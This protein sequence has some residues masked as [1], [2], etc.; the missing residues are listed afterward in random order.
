MG[1]KKT[2]TENLGV[3]I[4]ALV[5][6]LIVWGYTSKEKTETWSKTIPIT[7]ENLADTLVVT[8]EIP[9]VVEIEVTTSHLIRMWTGFTRFALV[10]DVSEAAPGHQRVSLTSRQIQLPDYIGYHNVA[11][12]DPRSIDLRLERLVTKRVKVTLATAGAI[13]EDLVLLDGALAISPSWITVTGPASVV[14]NINSVT[15]ESLDLARIKESVDR[16]LA[17]KIEGDRFR[18]EPDRVTVTVRVDERGDR[19][20]ANVPPTVLLDSDDFTATVIPNTVTLTLSGPR[21]VLDTLTYGDVS[22]LLNLGGLGEARYR[23]APEVILPPGLV[24]T[25]MSVDSLIV[26]IVKNAD[27]GTP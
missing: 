18:C 21:A 23:M 4:I 13:P 24:L 8:N 1:L 25:E 20:L 6:A 11:V 14:Q 26:D 19:V 12:R 10:L 9:R 16:D 5:V 27:A 7:L 2:F 17:V 15:T 3:K 22:V